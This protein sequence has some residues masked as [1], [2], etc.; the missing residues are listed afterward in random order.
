MHKTCLTKF[1]T[2]AITKSINSRF[3][4][5]VFTGVGRFYKGLSTNSANVYHMGLMHCVVVRS[6]RQ[7]TQFYVV[8]AMYVQRN[9]EARSR[10]QCC[11]G[12]AI[13]VTYSECVSVALV[14]QHAKGMR[15]IILS[16]V[17]CL[18]LPHFATLPHKPHDF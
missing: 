4:I 6:N 13:N 7:V 9:T 16:S 3:P 17:A 1:N 18:A 11:R 15:C 8:Q 10:N 5:N 2:A 12:K 14:I